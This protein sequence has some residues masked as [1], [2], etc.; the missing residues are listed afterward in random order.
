LEITPLWRHFTQIN[1][2]YKYCQ[3]SVIK[4]RR[5]LALTHALQDLLQDEGALLLVLVDLSHFDYRFWI[6]LHYFSGLFA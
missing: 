2:F 1:H 3:I 4:S 5:S 6:D